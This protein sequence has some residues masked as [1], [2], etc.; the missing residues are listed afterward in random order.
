MA[1]QI[2]HLPI[3][4]KIL[5]IYQKTVTKMHIHTIS[6]ER[7][8]N[9]H[10]FLDEIYS[11]VYKPSV[12]DPK[13]FFSDAD[14]TYIGSGFGS[15]FESGSGLFMKNT[16][17]FRSSKHRNKAGLFRKIHLNCRSSKYCQNAHFY[18]I[19]TFVQLNIC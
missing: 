1:G 6:G 10:S 11:T 13:L 9:E 19:C 12:V 2:L 17:D 16:F 18:K 4:P 14:P 8:N 3:P 15:G 7:S 5:D